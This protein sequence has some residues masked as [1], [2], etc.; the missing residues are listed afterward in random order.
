MEWTTVGAR[1]AVGQ[2]PSFDASTLVPACAGGLGRSAGQALLGC[3]PGSSGDDMAR[4][5]LVRQIEG[6]LVVKGFRAPAGAGL[7]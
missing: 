2:S 7:H 1:T 3:P 6:R 5:E 4:Q